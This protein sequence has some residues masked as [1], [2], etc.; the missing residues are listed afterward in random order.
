MPTCIGA[1]THRS[2][3]LVSPFWRMWTIGSQQVLYLRWVDCWAKRALHLLPVH[4]WTIYLL[5]AFIAFLVLLCHR[6]LDDLRF[7]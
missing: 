6:L 1:C 2:L 3:L 4:L 7:H 5:C